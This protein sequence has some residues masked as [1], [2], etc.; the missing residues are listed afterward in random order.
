[1]LP[2]IWLKWKN[3]SEQYVHLHKYDIASQVMP[4][5]YIYDAF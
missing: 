5:L 1:M 2:Q 3:K 4:N